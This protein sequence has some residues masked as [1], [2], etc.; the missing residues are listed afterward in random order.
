MNSRQR[1]SRPWVRRPPVTHNPA[2]P[3]VLGQG[4]PLRP[5]TNA[6]RAAIKSLVNGILKEYSLSTCGS[7]TDADLDDIES[8][9]GGNQGYFAVVEQAGNIIATVGVY[10]L[11]AD[12]CELR[13]MYAVPAA[14]G[15]GLG[16]YLLNLAIDK[17]KEIGYQRMVLETAALLKEAI[18]LYKK[19]GFKEYHPDKISAR[20]DQAYELMLKTGEQL[21]SRR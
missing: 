15:K 8:S 14:R 5:A 11:S 16:K 6:D 9:Y 13:K 17:A 21:T 19:Y 7:P 12:T 2:V 20:C 10:H 3:V 18:G 1:V 4:W